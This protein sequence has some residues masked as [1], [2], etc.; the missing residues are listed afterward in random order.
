MVLEQLGFSVTENHINLVFDLYLQ[1]SHELL[2]AF[3]VLNINPRHRF[4]G[5]MTGVLS[6]LFETKVREKKLETASKNK[7]KK[8]TKEQ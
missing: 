8:K 1:P 4:S 2:G 6:P 3:T 5:N 7:T